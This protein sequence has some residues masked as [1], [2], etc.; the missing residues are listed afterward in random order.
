MKK[1]IYYLVLI[2]GI[3]CP[4]YVFAQEYQVKELIPV[5]TVA[6]VN[7]EK[8]KY[9]DFI[10]SSSV[11]AKGNTKITFN[12]ISNNTMS[13]IP[14]S[15][16]LLLFDSNKKNI[17]IVTY[18]SNKDVS[19]NYAGFQLAGN[20]ASTFTINVVSTKY[21]VDGKKPSDVA[22]VSVLDENKYCQVGG[23]D[24]YE[25][26]TIDEITKGELSENVKK[27]NIDYKNLLKGSL[28]IIL[29][30]IGAVIISL[31]VT[32]MILNALYKRMY[33]KTTALAYIPIANVYITIKLAFG[34][35]VAPIFLLIY[36]IASGLYVVGITFLLYI[37]SFIETIAFIIVIIKLITKKYDM[38]I[39][40]PSIKTNIPQVPDA[41]EVSKY[42]VN[43]I[44]NVSDSNYISSDT[45]QE[46]IDLSYD[47]V[48]DGDSVFDISSNNFT[49]NA[50][51]T[52]NNDEKEE[53][54]EN[55]DDSDEEGKSDLS[56]FFQ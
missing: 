30:I 21:F 39:L 42:D 19:S 46:T 4:T 29:V 31:V 3:L 11:D 43:N 23:Y 12:S 8:L 38:L 54:K 51:V 28:I 55:E 10:Y 40:E 37:V 6:T 36:F 2:I 9:N 56:K 50:S 35:I 14:V 45:E 20:Q 27:N 44:N 32:G 25:G 52:S 13:K 34:N 5:D 33:A 26:L 7:T 47:D 17:G 22:Y 24:N 41:G 16:N 1:F 15:I 49:N 18:C 48:D 53:E